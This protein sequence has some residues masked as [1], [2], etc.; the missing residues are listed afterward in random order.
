QDDAWGDD[1]V[2]FDAWMATLTFP[3]T[4]MD[5]GHSRVIKTRAEARTEMERLFKLMRA[6]GGHRLRTLILMRVQTTDT[7]VQVATVRQML[8]RAKGIV[9][10]T[11]ITWTV[12]KTSKGWRIKEVFFD[13]PIYAQLTEPRS[14]R[15][16]SVG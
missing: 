3:L 2:D 12:V 13:K 11:P 9:A 16:R 10:E 4:E 7:T 6:D 14:T 5:H 8:T 1:G 15:G